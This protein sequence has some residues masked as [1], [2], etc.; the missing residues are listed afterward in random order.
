MDQTVGDFEVDNVNGRIT[1]DGIR[2]SGSAE[3]VNGP[4]AVSFSE[5]PP[6]ASLFKTVNGNV[7]ITLPE[8]LST[9]LKMK[10]LNGGLFTDFDVQTLQS[11]PIAVE[12]RGGRSIYRSNEFTR[13]RA[14]RGGPEITLETLNGNVHVLRAPR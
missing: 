5:A 1:M 11:G 8:G 2:G 7:T 10:T 3:T 14:G 13:V 6:A 9:D 12:R 4:V